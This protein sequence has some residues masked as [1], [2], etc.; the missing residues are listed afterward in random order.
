MV[1]NVNKRI[2]SSTYEIKQLYGIPMRVMVKQDMFAHKL[3]AFSERFGKANRDL[4]D[5]WFMLDKQW[6]VEKNIIKLRTG[7]PFEQFIKE[8]L[9]RL[10]T[11]P[12]HQ[13]LSGI[14]DL[15]DP[16]QKAWVKTHILTEVCF[17]LEARFLSS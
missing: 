16:K 17:L 15:L 7:I 11:Y 6:N 10:T 1:A 9:A 4:Y 3:V 8:L 5:V 14:G 13:I 12:K 2:F